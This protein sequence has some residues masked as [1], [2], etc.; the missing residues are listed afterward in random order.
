MEGNRKR[1]G[2]EGP[3][4]GHREEPM[5]EMSGECERDVNEKMML[6]GAGLLEKR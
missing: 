4:E 3:S 6:R 2:S 1:R 5:E